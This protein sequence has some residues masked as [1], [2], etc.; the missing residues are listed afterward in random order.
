MEKRSI[1][2]MIVVAMFAVVFFVV[3]SYS[4]DD[5]TTVED[6]AFNEHM[7]PPVPFAHDEHN[8]TAEI[9]DFH[10]LVDHGNRLHAGKSNCHMSADFPLYRYAARIPSG[11]QIL[12]NWRSDKLESG[13]GGINR[14]RWR[15]PQ[16]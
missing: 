6:S 10:A 11:G 8:E 1:M 16:S 9:E 5:V 14:R 4:Q 15:F 7:R 13:S 2:A 12:K 3:T